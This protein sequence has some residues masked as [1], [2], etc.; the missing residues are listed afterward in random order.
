[1]R[2]GPGPKWNGFALRRE[3]RLAA[4]RG[5]ADG[6]YAN[7]VEAFEGARYENTGYYR[8]QQRCF[9]ISGAR[10][11]AVCRQAISHIIDLY[12]GP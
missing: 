2:S 11:R 4:E 1:M 6:P 10:F 7:V 8:P 5:L 12:S 9:M 3:S